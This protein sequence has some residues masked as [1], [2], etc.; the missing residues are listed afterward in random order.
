MR[1]PSHCAGWSRSMK[2]PGS[3]NGAVSL[4]SVFPSKQVPLTL[5]MAPAIHNQVWK[6]IAKFNIQY[7]LGACH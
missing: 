6:K 4:K 1:K 2:R 7:T 3:F 5:R